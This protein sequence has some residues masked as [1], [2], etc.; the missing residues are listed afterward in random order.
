[1]EHAAFKGGGNR[2]LSIVCTSNN[3]IMGRA[4]IA[5]TG[6]FSFNFDI[7]EICLE[8]CLE[9]KNAFLFMFLLYERLYIRISAQG[10]KKFGL[11]NIRYRKIRY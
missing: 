8:I 4:D 7:I 11:R 2:L 5:S 6:Y 1:M 9:I 10:M 3:G